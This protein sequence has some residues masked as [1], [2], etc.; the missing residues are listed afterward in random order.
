MNIRRVYGEGAELIWNDRKRF[1]GMPLS[2][3]RYMLIRK[4]GAWFKIFQNVG[5]LYSQ[6]DEVNLY[7]ICDITLRQSLFG[8]ILNTGTVILYSADESKSTL[9]LK[10]IK[11]PFRVRDMISNYVEEQRKVHNVRLAEFH[12]HD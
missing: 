8:K 4:E 3:T 7:R 10:N 2:F 12:N 11:N 5:L 1:L 9:V 6:I